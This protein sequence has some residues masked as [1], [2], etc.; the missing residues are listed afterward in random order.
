MNESK[1]KQ[2][3]H[4]IK[5]KLIS[6][7][8]IEQ[9]IQCLKRNDW[10]IILDLYFN[11]SHVKF[12][13]SEIVQKKDETK[14][15]RI[16]FTRTVYIASD[17]LS[18]LMGGG[19]GGGRHD[20]N[21]D[22]EGNDYEPDL[23]DFDPE[24]ELDEEHQED[25]TGTYEW[26]DNNEILNE[27]I[28]TMT[29]NPLRLPLNL[30]TYARNDKQVEYEQ[31]MNDLIAAQK[32]L[33]YKIKYDAD[34]HV[35]KDDIRKF[36]RDTIQVFE[37]KGHSYSLDDINTITQCI[38]SMT[39][40]YETLI[41]DMKIAVKY[42]VSSIERA[43]LFVICTVKNTPRMLRQI[44]KIFLEDKNEEFKI[45]F[46]LAFNKII[47][48]CYRDRYFELSQMLGVPTEFHLRFSRTQELIQRLTY[49]QKIS[50]I[51]IDF[52][53]Y[54]YVIVH[55]M[56]NYRTSHSFDVIKTFVLNFYYFPERF[57]NLNRYESISNAIQDTAAMSMFTQTHQAQLSNTQR[58]F[59]THA[60]L[61]VNDETKTNDETTV[62]SSNG[63]QPPLP[64]KTYY[65]TLTRPVHYEPIVHTRIKKPIV[66]YKPLMLQTEPKVNPHEVAALRA[67]IAGEISTDV[68]VINARLEPLRLQHGLRFGVN[69]TVWRHYI[70]EAVN[71]MNTY[72][73]TERP[74]PIT[75]DTID[76]MFHRHAETSHG[77]GRA[78]FTPV[79]HV[80]ALQLG[81]S[82][83]ARNG[84]LQVASQFNF[85]ES[86][87]PRYSP[88]IDYITDRT[89]GPRASLG[90]LAALL[91]RDQAFGQ[92][93][94]PQTIFDSTLI[95]ADIYEG[96]Y[97]MPY[98]ANEN[99]KALALYLKKNTKKLRILAQ[100]GLP[101]IGTEPMLQIFTAAPSYQ[102]TMIDITKYGAS[103]CETLVVNQYRAVA[104]IAVLRCIET[105]QRVPL[106]LTLVGQGAF[107]NPE[108]VL[109]KAFAA[110]NTIVQAHDIDVYIHGYTDDDMLKITGNLP[111]NLHLNPLM[112]TDAFFA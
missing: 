95:G 15:I 62:S 1:Q 3:I 27:Q 63:S 72:V 75:L 106:H 36:V 26:N 32:K 20:L 25:E 100:W 82:R 91:Q 60:V 51:R 30:K 39:Y 93:H 2:L 43:A 96:G 33:K 97:L 45:Q 31:S 70:T 8:S 74:L 86:M 104:Q 42:K 99:E 18:P 16:H 56:L 24:T 88:V 58:R 79:F 9:L 64:K 4:S 61:N 5:K 19:G 14:Q 80:D 92:G 73:I 105:R 108:S 107:R 21:R 111:S 35:K 7:L 81:A 77:N 12:I 29:L 22:V 54:I 28:N 112:N 110:V 102:N 41:V 55:L 11:L 37:D 101:D 85:L 87:S 66:P 90:S 46:F 17:V 69:D 49:L 94:E 68:R 57:F 89:Q 53:I 59:L 83:R 40:E 10:E 65:S 6:S 34:E 67:I 23:G 47:S 103:I 98:R 38:K 48:I 78:T 44:M 71:L 50:K 109:Q 76:V 84:I 13:R 52:E